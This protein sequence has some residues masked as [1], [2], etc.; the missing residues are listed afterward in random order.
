MSRELKLARMGDFPGAVLDAVID[1]RN[2]HNDLAMQYLSNEKI[3]K[4]FAQ[5]LLETL[6]GTTDCRP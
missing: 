1:S 2:T 4:G 3:A 6:V 5:L